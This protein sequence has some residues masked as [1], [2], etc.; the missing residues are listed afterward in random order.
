MTPTGV[1][2]R[3][4]NTGTMAG[5]RFGSAAAAGVLGNG[6]TNADGIAVFDVGINTLTSSSVPIDA[7]FFGSA[8]GTAVVTGGTA[9][10]QL[11]INDRYS[12]GKL[13]T[14]SFI[15]PDPASADVLVAT[16]S[17]N[18]A[19]GI[20][21]T[22]R[23]WVV[24]TA[25]ATSEISLVGAPAQPDLTVA[26]SAPASGIVNQPFNYS[27]VVS[28]PGSV[29]ASGI[30]VNF[31]L[32]ASTGVTYN[33]AGVAS[34]FTAMQSGT[35][36]SFSSGTLAAGA[37][38]TLTV[39]VTPTV[40]GNI[41][42]GTALV[43]PANA[44]AESNETNNSAP[45]VTV[46]VGAGAPPTIVVANTTT[47]YL[48]ASAVSSVISD[49]T[50][51]A[52]T[53][54]ID[55]TVADPDSPINSLVV[56]ASSSNAGVVSNAN[57]ILTGTGASRNLK[58]TPAGVGFATIT[59]TVSDGTNTASYTISYAA[60][61]ASTATS[62]F[63]TGR[64]DAS[65]V[66]NAGG[67]Y[68]F[69]GDDENNVLRLY[70][71]SQSGLPVY[72]FDAGPFLAL[73]DL[74][75]GVP[76]EVDIEASAQSGNRIYWFGSQSNSESGNSRPNRDRVFATD[77]TGSGAAATLSYVSRYDF[78]REDLI[79][80]DVNNTHGKG[81]NYYGLAASADAGMNSKTNSG[82]NI[83]GTEFA[84]NGTTMYIGFR[85][86]QVP[87][88][89][90]TKA[91]VV[92]VTNLTNIL[93]ASGGTQ[94]SAQFG[95]PIEMDLGGRGIREMKKNAANQYLI[96]AGPAGGNM[97][98]A[99]NDFRL[100]T[101]TG[102]PTDAPVLRAGDVSGLS[103][104]AD[105]SSIESI[106]E[107]PAML[108]ATSSIQF[109]LDNGDMVY[110]ND[111]T[112]AKDLTQNNFKKSRSD[113][114]T[115]GAALTSTLAANP[116]ML[117]NFTALT[118][119]AS[120]PQVYTL[121]GTN[122]TA[123][124]SV[125]V[126]AG[127]EIST[128]GT[129]YSTTAT[130]PQT[131]GAISQTIAVRLASSATPGAV[132]GTV[133]N[134]SGSATATVT[135][136]GIVS[137]PVGNAP[138]KVVI[139]QVYG[140]GGNSSATLRYDF[141]ELF[142]AGGTAVD[143]TGWSVQYASAA[144]QFGTGTITPIS[145][146]IQPGGY[147]LV[148]EASGANTAAANLPTP[149]AIG[150]IALS[151]TNGKVALSN[152]T[153][154]LGA[155]C[156]GSAVIDLVGY[157]ST[158]SCFEGSAPTSVLTNTTAALRKLN[159]CTDTDDN[160]ADFTTGT[161]TPR[162]SAS[163]VNLCNPVSVQPTIT[164]T[165][166]SL[167]IAYT[168]GN[169]P[170]STTVLVSGSNLNV[171]TGTVTAVSSSTAFVVSP[172]SVPF[173]GSALA[174]TTFT[175]QLVA[176]LTTVASPYSATITFT[177]GGA[178][179]MVPV[180]GI[181]SA[182]VGSGITPIA[183][184]RTQVGQTV[185]IQGTVTVSGQLGTKQLYVEDNTGGVLVYSGSTSDYTT[186]A[187]IGDVVKL[188]GPVAVY[189]G[190]IE[191]NGVTAFTLVSTGNPAPTPT[192]ITLDQIGNY[193][194]RLV[195]IMGASVS[196]SSTTFSAGNVALSTNVNSGTATLR[197]SGSSGLVGA[198]Q[199]SAP[200]SITGIADRFV[201]S[202]T[203]T[204]SDNIQLLPRL[205]TDVAG[206]TEPVNNDVFCG[207]P[208]TSGTLT[209]D[210]TFDFA[211][212]N[213]EFFGASAGTI[214]CS[215]GD[216]QYQNQGPSNESL[217]A[218]NVKKVLTAINADVF[219]LEEVSD[220]TLLQNNLPAGYALS[221]S[222]RFSYYFQDECTQT[223]T[224]GFVFGP[225][226]FAQKVCVA[227]N[228]TTV[229]SVSASPLLSDYYGYPNGTATSAP[230]NWSSGRLPYLF[231]A[232]ATINGVS[233][234][235]NIIGI[236]AKSGSATA[237]YNRR[238]QD[239]LD[240]YNLLTNSAT[241]PGPLGAGFTKEN[242][243]IAGDFNDNITG[244]IATG[245]NSSYKPFVD[246]VTNFTALT[247][248]LEDVQGCNTFFSATGSTSFLDHIVISN[249]LFNAYVP[250]SVGIQSSFSAI[251]TNFTN[252]TSDHRPVYAR[253]D[254]SKIALPLSATLVASTSVCVGS[255]ASLSLTVAGLGTGAT[256]SYTITN[257]T[258]STTASGV[259]ASAVQTSVVTTVA[260]SFTATVLTSTSAS[261][262]AASGNV[263]INALP[264]NASLTSGT[265][266]CTN[267]SVTLTASATGGTSYTLNGGPTSQTNTTGQFVVSTAGN[268]TAIIANASGCTATAS[269]NGD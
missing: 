147:Y 233:R 17:F 62:R 85:A 153:T 100:Y 253:F 92:P 128:D 67:G 113:Y 93:A 229:T 94:G 238:K 26:L 105:G 106:V 102:V 50:D 210:Q 55:F 137:A 57:L 257:G 243:I 173:S 126:S 84:P 194:G 246:D 168:Q 247:Q 239:V 177:G 156:T 77:V 191:I 261:T 75:G 129:T 171:A 139:S 73:T 263:A 63:H 6:G 118:G 184:A 198:G 165:P 140:G 13:Q 78:L 7:I 127:Y 166:N 3:T 242:I 169:G 249:E 131:T 25:T 56:S 21:P 98:T 200:F 267:T 42:S 225:T 205:L 190:G 12:G 33:S 133:T 1:K 41:T 22:A 14:T 178:T 9:G 130:V 83:E 231:V 192:P 254:L 195:S 235:L 66:Q 237:D 226:K 31:S 174:S 15:A 148:Q 255:P 149:D 248:P 112:I 143:V 43:D 115:I 213:I 19:T 186:E 71:R 60:S 70:N 81:A 202:A 58:I 151:G 150:T 107:I 110:Y 218:Q 39:N 224:G 180:T 185:T 64:S 135:L 201:A 29:S 24:G 87:T 183:T 236:H 68:M 125:S 207:T 262:T 162:N 35:L 172:A 45:G 214:V 199:P 116:T 86:P 163:P 132:S 221:C 230:S 269:C 104:S 76:R 215:N 124:A 222:N 211:A 175:V 187:Q 27:L 44:I 208:I 136:S 72:T 61:A 48:S 18:P 240:L 161:P 232:D 259:S 219:V 79:A 23:T 11:P 99:P 258:N 88:N 54:G 220:Q 111:G 250:N 216:L 65:T 256:Y 234:R 101:W 212:F 103:G 32:P 245:Q 188:T 181:V 95:A 123:S 46:N 146:V 52:T 223:P 155:N 241:G 89:G 196:P 36:V 144:N 117:S 69:V 120:A 206:A 158:A 74:S 59:V 4:I 228:T 209:Q 193:Q 260:G 122:L 5:D 91:L 203:T 182:S 138:G 145:G 159:G 28:N 176:G 53:L 152:T 34:A 154:S 268:Y 114:A 121:T 141:I 37:S 179:T 2:L 38:T 108:D 265:L 47:P 90:R 20:Y 142:N 49:P 217:Q 109:L 157:G 167:N 266:T 264:T 189:Q 227:Y 30:A 8:A 204:G 97:G 164:A 40:T 252:T 244:S 170:A 10:Y 16:G 96:I 82:Y 80:W 119:T 251:T 51:P 197:I 160:A 134:T